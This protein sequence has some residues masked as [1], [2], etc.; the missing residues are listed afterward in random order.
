MPIV[1]TSGYSGA[2]L[3]ERARAVAI[4]EVLRKP[5]QTKD[6]AECFQ[7]VLR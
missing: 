3:H 4:Q 1:L 7:R 5:L 2:P 6:I